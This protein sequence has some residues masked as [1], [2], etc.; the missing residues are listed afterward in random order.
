MESE[1][2]PHSPP[3]S[4]SL[5]VVVKPS[6]FLLLL[7]HPLLF[8]VILMITTMIF[9]KVKALGQ[10]VDH[11]TAKSV[12][13]GNC[14]WHAQTTDARPRSCLLLE[15][16]LPIW[17]HVAC[18]MS[19]TTGMPCLWF[20]AFLS[21]KQSEELKPLIKQLCADSVLFIFCQSLNTAFPSYCNTGICSDLPFTVNKAFSMHSTDFS[22]RTPLISHIF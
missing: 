5:E 2:L 9:N 19:I 8:V 7:P 10:V 6:S 12:N 16:K 21:L 11:L 15:A 22:D 3:K 14:K 4:Y 1:G 20:L 18:H 17:S 13:T